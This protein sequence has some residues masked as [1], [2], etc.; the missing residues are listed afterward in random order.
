MELTRNG[1]YKEHSHYY[2]YAASTTKIEASDLA[3]LNEK[4]CRILDAT[5]LAVLMSAMLCGVTQ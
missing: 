3:P 5:R 4:Q 2:F 1:E